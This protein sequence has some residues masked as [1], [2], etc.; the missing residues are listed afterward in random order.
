MNK[1]VL[2]ISLLLFLAWPVAAGGQTP[3]LE[4]APDLPDTPIVALDSFV[5]VNLTVDEYSTDLKGYSVVLWNNPAILEIDSIT[6]GPLLAS[7]GE[8]TFFDVN[9]DPAE[10]YIYVDGAILG[11]GISIDGAGTLASLWFTSVGYGYDY[12]AFLEYRLRDAANQQLDYDTSVTW[13]RVC[14]FLG[15]VN[16]DNKINVSDIV[17]LI[18]YVFADGPEPIPNWTV[19][20]VDCTGFT[21]VSDIVY[22]INYV[23]AFGP[24]PCDICSNDP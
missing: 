23:F 17:Y 24:P 19:G 12:F 3:T 6:E 10:Q 9:F 15:D 2:S 13:L 8:P 18:D 11:D 7:A 16:A 1:I 20:D 5:V 22:L 21:N 14:P 4:F